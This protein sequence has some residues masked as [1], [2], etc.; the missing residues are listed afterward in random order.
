MGNGILKNGKW[1]SNFDIKILGQRLREIRKD[2]GMTQTN[3]AQEL[4]VAQSMV[5]KVE[6]GLPVLS[7]VVIGYMLFVAQRCNI[8]YLMGD[9]FDITDKE[10]LY[11]VSFSLN[12]I[13]RAK[14]EALQQDLDKINKEMDNVKDLL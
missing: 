6:K 10:A 14:I 8:N 2:L 12:S 1:M 3:I 9:H 4:G 11:D 7:P 5:S 13:A